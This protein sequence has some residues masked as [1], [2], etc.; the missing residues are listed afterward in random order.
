MVKITDL[1]S[2]D[3]AHNETHNSF[4]EIHVFFYIGKYFILNFRMVVMFEDCCKKVELHD[5]IFRLK[6]SLFN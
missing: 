3:K 1:Y 4:V 5:R 2:Q 6:V